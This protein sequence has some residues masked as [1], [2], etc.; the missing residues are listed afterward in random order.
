MTITWL[1]EFSRIVRTAIQQ[2]LNSGYKKYRAEEGKVGSKS[3]SL[4][5]KDNFLK[6]HNDVVKLLKKNTSIRNI[7]KL[8]DKSTKTVQKVK[9]LM[10]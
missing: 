1:V 5:S 9:N 7:V 3:C 4:E 6:M 10:S 8:T 2:P